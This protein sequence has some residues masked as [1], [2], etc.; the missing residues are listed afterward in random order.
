MPGGTLYCISY[1]HTHC[2]SFQILTYLLL[3]C[4]VAMPIMLSHFDAGLFPKLSSRESHFCMNNVMICDLLPLM[5]TVRYFFKVTSK[6]TADV[7]KVFG[8][9]NLPYDVTCA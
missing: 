6:I 4:D 1:I 8:I 2:N 7:F 5:K 9:M 3:F